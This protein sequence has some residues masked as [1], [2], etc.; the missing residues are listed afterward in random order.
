MAVAAHAEVARRVERRAAQ[1]ARR[2]TGT[3]DLQGAARKVQR[4]LGLQ[5]DSNDVTRIVQLRRK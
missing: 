4:R 3:D 1:R 5:L 2:A